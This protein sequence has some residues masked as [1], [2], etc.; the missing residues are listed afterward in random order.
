VSD[1]VRGGEYLVV[2]MTETG[3]TWGLNPEPIAG[4]IDPDHGIER[5]TWLQSCRDHPSIIAVYKVERVY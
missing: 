5:K 1:F 4:R 3:L 2:Q